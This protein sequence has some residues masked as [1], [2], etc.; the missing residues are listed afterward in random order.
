MTAS[1]QRQRHRPLSPTHHHF[2]QLLALDILTL[3][4]ASLVMLTRHCFTVFYRF[5]EHAPA[6]LIDRHDEHPRALSCWQSDTTSFVD[7]SRSTV[8]YSPEFG[9]SFFSTFLVGVC[10]CIFLKLHIAT[11]CDPVILFMLIAILCNSH[12]S[13]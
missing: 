11:Q 6:L 3:T 4:S 13:S 5:D 7:V 12:W 2:R 10:M 9:L 8:G 1:W